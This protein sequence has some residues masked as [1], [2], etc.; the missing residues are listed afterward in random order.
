MSDPAWTE[1][2]EYIEGRLLGD[3]PALAAALKANASAGLP[4]IDVSPAHGKMLHL[5]A[6]MMNARRVLEVGTLGGYST[7]WLAKALPENGRVVTLEIDSRHAEVARSNLESAGLAGRVDVKV[8]PALDSLQA[9]QE[10]GEEPFDLSFI[11]ADKPNN[12]NYLRAALAL[13]RPGSAIIVDN[14]VR[15][16]EVLNGKGDAN[17]RGA[18]ELFDAIAAEPRLTATAVQTVGRKKWDGFVLA[19]VDA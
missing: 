4:A 11:D 13:S 17:A 10:A 15:E 8:G 5:F 3:D 12:A 6:R 2:D 9:M 7:I 14:V 18:R 16:G 1:V 19:V